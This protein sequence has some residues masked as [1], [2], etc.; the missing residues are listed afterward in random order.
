LKEQYGDMDFEPKA[1]DE[2]RR[3]VTLAEAIDFVAECLEQDDV[4]ALAS[5]IETMQARLAY[6][7]D[8]AQY[9]IPAIF[10]QLKDLHEKKDLHSAEIPGDA[11]EYELRFSGYRLMGMHVC[12]V[13]HSDGWIIH[14]TYLTRG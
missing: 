6:D 12:F 7:P 11:S 14:D 9:F 3:F 10:S 2:V 4:S 13:K 8:Y 5:E 1:P